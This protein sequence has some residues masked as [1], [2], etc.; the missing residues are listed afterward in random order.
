M[1]CTCE[2]CEGEGT[3]ECPECGGSGVIEVS[4]PHMSWH[5]THPRYAELNQLKSDFLYVQQLARRLGEIN[6]KFRVKYNM[7]ARRATEDI[8]KA[9]QKLQ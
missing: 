8:T 9:I 7:D 2:N 6:P 5:K 3:I 1:N 4:V